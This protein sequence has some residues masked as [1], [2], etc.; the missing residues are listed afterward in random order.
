MR[1]DEHSPN[2]L[3]ACVAEAVG[4][5]ILVFAGTAVA[6]AAILNRPI[7]GATYNSLAVGLAFGVTVAA[8][9]SAL[10]HV[11]GAHFNPAVTLAL[12]CTGKFPWKCVPMYIF[13]QFTGAILAAI[14]VLLTYGESARSV[15]FLAATYPAA[16]VTDSQA[17]L[18]E[19]L[20]TFILVFVI[21]AVATDERATSSS[22][23]AAIGFALTA[24][25]LIGGPVS[26]AAVNPARALG[27][28]IVAGKF[29]AFWVYLIAPVVGGI[30]AAW[31]YDGFVKKTSPPKNRCEN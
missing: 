17:F 9:I 29:T 24:V 25:I 11:S 31:F 4:T 1:K 10:G 2:I 6:T 21:V 12:S 16:G 13:G 28:M 3:R 14:A 22:A 26:G 15:A 20:I 8:L 5:F 27:P 19:A 7:T 18:M 30:I 23:S